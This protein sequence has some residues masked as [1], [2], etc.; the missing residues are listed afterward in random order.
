[1]DSSPARLRPGAACVTHSPLPLASPLTREVEEGGVEYKLHLCTPSPD[2]LTGLI[3]QMMW[4][5]REGAGAAVYHLGVADDG[6]QVGLDARDLKASLDTVEVMAE[7][8]SARVTAVTVRPAAATHLRVAEVHVFKSEPELEERRSVTVNVV[9]TGATG[10][11]KSTLIACLVQVVADDGVGS[12]R[13]RVHRHRHE[14]EVGITSSSSRHVLGFKS[15]VRLNARATGV[16]V[17]GGTGIAGVVG[18]GPHVDVL[19]TGWTDAALTHAATST[20]TLID[21][22]GSSKFAHTTLAAL[23][24]PALDAVQVTLDARALAAGVL[25]DVTAAYLQVVIG[26]QLPFYLVA[27][28]MDAAPPDLDLNRALEPILAAIHA[29]M[30]GQGAATTA[31][32]AAATSAPALLHVTSPATAQVAAAAMPLSIPVFAVSAVSRHGFN[33]LETFLSHLRPFPARFKSPSPVAA[34]VEDVWA[35]GGDAHACMALITRGRVNV[36]DVYL[37]GPDEGGNL[38]PVTITSLHVQR[39]PVASAGEGVVATVLAVWLKS[40]VSVLPGEVRRGQVLL[41]TTP[42]PPSARDTASP[43]PAV[44]PLQRSRS[45][46]Y[47]NATTTF[48]VDVV[49]SSQPFRVNGVCQALCATVRQ[50]VQ[51]VAMLSTT[52]TAGGYSRIKLRARF[53]HCCEYVTIG[54]PILLRIPGGMKI[55]VGTV[56]KLCEDDSRAVSAPPTSG[57]TSAPG[58]REPTGRGARRMRSRTS[59]GPPVVRNS[60]ILSPSDSGRA[61]IR[62]APT[63]SGDTRGHAVASGTASG[64]SAARAEEEED[65]DG[66]LGTIGSVGFL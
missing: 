60:G 65:D 34:H 10:V 32:A 59:A 30:A 38:N 62:R 56:G 54:S 5:L 64:A 47:S 18:V 4:R 17:A 51:V 52:P 7:A 12:A 23:A 50:A 11:G 58:A 31:A 20:V 14:V 22:P 39:Q 61:D 45:G 49:S 28:H 43:P 55:A 25:D 6:V 1:M 15:H 57:S 21:T 24:G 29:A 2:R 44:L 33:L 37:L 66:I 46:R 63:T 41:T 13:F 9:V 35:L 3:T 8:A 42:P 16:L 36:G 19:S 26:L 53:V 40:G 48:E 27:T